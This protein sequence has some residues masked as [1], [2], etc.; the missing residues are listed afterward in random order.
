RGPPRW[1]ILGPAR[2]TRRPAGLPTDS[3]LRSASVFD[4]APE[5]KIK[6][7]SADQKTADFVSEKDVRARSK[8]DQKQAE[9]YLIYGD[10]NVG[11]DLPP[12]GECQLMQL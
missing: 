3:S 12:M 10:Q 11:G 5:I 6:I 8:A 1:A 9:I 2:L 4:G 7:K